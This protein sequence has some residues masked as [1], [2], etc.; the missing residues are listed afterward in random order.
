LLIMRTT[1]DNVGSSKVRNGSVTVCWATL[2]RLSLGRNVGN[3]LASE[4]D[5][6][7]GWT[8]VAIYRDEQRLPLVLL[9][10]VP[11]GHQ[12]LVAFCESQ[13]YFCSRVRAAPGGHT[14]ARRFE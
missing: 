8:L 13:K 1:S 10:L 9:P 11:L 14:R 7:L 4:M 2:L 12:G 3:A 6:R 5:A